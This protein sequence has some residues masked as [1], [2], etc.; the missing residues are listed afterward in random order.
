MTVKLDKS[1]KE[2]TQYNQPHRKT[3]QEPIKPSGFM[4]S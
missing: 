1:D 4:G 3:D 2:D